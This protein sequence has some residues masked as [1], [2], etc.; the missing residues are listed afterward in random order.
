MTDWN[1]E[2][3]L[4]DGWVETTLGNVADTNKNSVWRNYSFEEILYLD[5]GSITKWKID[6]FQKVNFSDAPSRAKRL[7]KHEDII[8]STVRPNQEHYGY[9]E[10][11]EDNLVVSTGFVVIE[12]NKDISDS[13]F[14]YYFLTQKRITDELHQTA[15]HSTST[16]PSIKPSDIEN[17]KITL[18]KNKEEQKAIA[19]VLSS[20]D[21]K[22]ELLRE[23]NKTLEATAQTIF[24]EWFG[25]Y[26]IDDELPEGWRVGKITE[27]IKRAPISYRCIKSD[28]DDNWITPI[29]D[30]WTNWL[31][32]Y[33]N[34]NPDFEASKENPVVVFTNHTCNYWFIDYPFCA[35]Q[36]VLPY[37]W[38][39]WYDEYFIYFM[40]KWSIKFIEYKWHWPNFVSKNFVIPPIEKAKKFSEIAKSILQKIS[41]NNKQIQLLWKSRDVL[42]PKLMK[43]EVRVEF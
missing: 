12:N 41:Y 9:L 5:T 43:G 30:Q 8:Y 10:N 19:S 40:T 6:S 4:P 15:E 37:H 35:I 17:L 3:S 16:Y 34:R 39:G 27:I 14:I 32:W 7:T 13:K 22:I 28:I 20:F 26:G 2:N 33:T 18:P 25:K 21:D 1:I 23:Q 29:L 42:L 38:A 36:N 11:P 24:K 31:Y